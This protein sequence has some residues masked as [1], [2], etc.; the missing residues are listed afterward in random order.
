[1]NTL[2][3]NLIIYRPVLSWSTGKGSTVSWAGSTWVP[4]T[5]PSTDRMVS[6]LGSGKERFTSRVA[7]PVEGVGFNTTWLLTTKLTTLVVSTSSLVP[8]SKA[9]V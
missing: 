9:D 6:W 4:T 3:S 1:M 5:C 8:F 2:F 7:D